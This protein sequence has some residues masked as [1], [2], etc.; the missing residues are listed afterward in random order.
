MKTRLAAC[1]NIIANI[2]VIYWREGEIKY[3][4]ECQLQIKTSNQSLDDIIHYIK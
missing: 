3:N 1:V 4:A 2:G